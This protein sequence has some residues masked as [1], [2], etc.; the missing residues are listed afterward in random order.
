MAALSGPSQQFL[1]RA[2]HRYR[3]RWLSLLLPLSLFAQT[4]TTSQTPAPVPSSS[5]PRVQPT[6][7][8][9]RPIS[10]SG[11]VS[12]VGGGLPERIVIERVCNGVVRQEGYA[13]SRGDFSFQVGA[14]NSSVL[15]DASSTFD[16]IVPTSEQR[17][18][19]QAGLSDRDLA[20]CEVR[21]SVPGYVSDALTLGFRRALDNPYLGIIYLHPISKG[22]DRTA[23]ITTA[24]A[25]KNAVKA[26]EKG[27]QSIGSK[28]W[29]DAERYFS[30]ALREYPKYAAAWFA[31]GVLLQDQKKLDAAT[32][33]YDEA[34]RADAKFIRPYE[35]LAIMA[36]TR[37]DWSEVARYTAEV[38]KLDPYVDAD[39]YYYSAVANHNLKNV[40]IAEEHAREAARLDAQHRNPRIHHVLG[41][42]LAQKGNYA[43]AAENLR[44][45]LQ[46]SPTAADAVTVREQL[47]YLERTQQEQ[48]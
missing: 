42:V 45:Y 31:L 2:G 7:G 40:G 25:P 26:F 36:V 18:G 46:L 33:A 28:K 38:F 6:D 20:G 43:E 13:D 48:R 22:D 34:I 30:A 47:S 44:L 37:G 41:I 4:G 1:K 21:A 10:L 32:R 5:A 24:M 9:P 14:L 39:F 11:K 23:S 17:L 3:L 35:Q 16:R 15:P 29:E 27:M 12:V 19:A 8:V